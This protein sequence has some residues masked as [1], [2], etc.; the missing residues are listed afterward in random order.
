MKIFVNDA[1]RSYFEMHDAIPRLNCSYVEDYPLNILSDFSC[2]F[3]K[4]HLSSSPTWCPNVCRLPVIIRLTSELVLCSQQ[5]VA[6]TSDSW[7]NA[8][9]NNHLHCRRISW[10]SRYKI[11]SLSSGILRHRHWRRWNKQSVINTYLWKTRHK[12]HKRIICSIFPNQ[13]YTIPDTGYCWRQA[14]H[15]TYAPICSSRLWLIMMWFF[16]V[17]II[18]LC[19][20]LTMWLYVVWFFVKWL[21]VCDF[22]SCD[23]TSMGGASRGLGGS[24]PPCPCS[25]PQLPP[26]PLLCPP[27][28]PKQNEPEKLCPSRKMILSW[29]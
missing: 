19:D 22:M 11:A 23:Y 7:T 24:C 9:A 17:V 10:S 16:D 29:Q 21:Y 14:E 25:A 13:A 3:V 6:I 20:Y 26:V 5:N 15:P 28:A 2:H 1:S 27:A 12:V 4:R 8:R 18:C